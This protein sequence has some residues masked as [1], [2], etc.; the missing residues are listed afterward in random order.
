MPTIG[1]LERR[2]GIEQTP[3]A[4]AAF[5]KP[6][7]HLEARAMLDAG[8]AELRRRIEAQDRLTHPDTPTPDE[9][10][11]LRSFAAEHGRYWKAAL[12][13]QWMTASACPVLQGLRNRLGPSWLSR[14]RLK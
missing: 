5:W 3:E 9:L 13:R 6:F 12:G 11:A 1:K 10:A 14:Y 8:C 7:A 4:R 2:A